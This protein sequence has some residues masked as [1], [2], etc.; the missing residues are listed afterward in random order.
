M[1]LPFKF[2]AHFGYK[3]NLICIISIERKISQKTP[4]DMLNLTVMHLRNKSELIL[5]G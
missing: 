4:N 1:Q 2:E 5:A 3:K